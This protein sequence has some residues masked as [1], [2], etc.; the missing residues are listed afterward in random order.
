MAIN[1][2][3]SY[4][5]AD[6]SMLLLQL[7]HGRMYNAQQAC[8]G[9]DKTAVAG[10]RWSIGIIGR[11]AG[12]QWLREQLTEFSIVAGDIVAREDETRSSFYVVLQGE[13]AATRLSRG[14]QIPTLRLLRQAFSEPSRCYREHLPLAHS[15]RSPMGALRC[16][17]R[18]RFG[19]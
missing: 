12:R 5:V 2:K 18:G 8:V 19:N 16:G 4:L 15:G 7:S 9:P 3:R 11:Q 10:R 1:E 6:N 13:V 14:Q 17:Q